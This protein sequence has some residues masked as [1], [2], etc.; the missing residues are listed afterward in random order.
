MDRLALGHR[1]VDRVPIATVRRI[2]VGYQPD[3]KENPA[4]P[5]GQLLTGD[6]NLINVQLNIDYVLSD[7]SS[8]SK[9]LS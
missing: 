9:I 5:V 8:A 1:S 7:D 4:L 6:Q 3:G 2:V